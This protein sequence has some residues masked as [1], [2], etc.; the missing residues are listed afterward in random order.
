MIDIMNKKKKKL[1]Q[2]EIEFNNLL[3]RMTILKD[4][5]DIKGR[6]ITIDICKDFS[7]C[8]GGRVISQGNYSGELFRKLFL[9]PV[10][11]LS[12]HL[13]I[14][15]IIIKFDG[16]YGYSCGFLE[17]AF[18]GLVRLYGTE[19]KIEKYQFISE[20]DPSVIDEVIEYMRDALYHETESEELLYGY[21]DPIRMSVPTKE[22]FMVVGHPRESTM[23]MLESLAQ[24]NPDPPIFVPEGLK[25]IFTGDDEFQYYQTD[26]LSIMDMFKGE[27]M[28]GQ[29]EL[30]KQIVEDI[31]RTNDIAKKDE[32]KKK[33][34]GMKPKRAKSPKS[35]RTH[36]RKSQKRKGA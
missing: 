6:S 23:A 9:E 27:K 10:H 3:T 33:E 28:P 8:P 18:G 11:R 30:M 22:A 7:E 19:I 4:R 34:K 2:E 24:R 12:M 26:E 1:T 25:A 15:K 13:A 32:R 17:E 14:N 16:S 20:E 5:I 36:K 31:K 21:P 29:E 35:R